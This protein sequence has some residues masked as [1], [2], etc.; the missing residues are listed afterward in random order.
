MVSPLSR[1]L[2]S[3]R[4]PADPSPALLFQSSATSS[5][6]ARPVSPAEKTSN[7]EV[8]APVATGVRSAYSSPS[9]VFE[10]DRKLTVCSASY[11]QASSRCWSRR[12]GWI[13]VRRRKQSDN[14]Q[15]LHTR[16]GGRP[17]GVSTIVSPLV[18]RS[19][20]EVSSQVGKEGREPT[21]LA[22]CS[23]LRS[24]LCSFLLSVLLPW[25]PPLDSRLTFLPFAR[26]LVVPARYQRPLRRRCPL[27][28]LHRLHLLPPHLLKD[29]QD[30]HQALDASDHPSSPYPTHLPLS[31]PRPLAYGGREERWKQSQEPSLSTS[32]SRS[33]AASLQTQIKTIPLSLFSST[34]ACSWRAAVA[35][36]ALPSGLLLPTFLPSAP[37]RAQPTPTPFS[38]LPTRTL[39]T[40]EMQGIGVVDV[41]VLRRCLVGPGGGGGDVAKGC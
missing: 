17:Q 34:D 29:H 24:S 1:P 22:G 30:R 27:P 7:S 14:A 16:R 12:Q 32:S 3:R 19:R 40:L 20:G 10:R 35:V 31:Y 28:R 36:F 9:G 26:A 18:F 38:T 21:E 8:A 39:R 5:S 41:L 6:I 23:S 2:P 11:H 33:S 13:L 4:S 15:A 37:S 25:T